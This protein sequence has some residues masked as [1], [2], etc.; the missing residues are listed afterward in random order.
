MPSPGALLR[1]APPASCTVYA[2][3]RDGAQDASRRSCDAS[4][5]RG[6]LR[7]TPSRRARTRT[8]LLHMH[9]HTHNHETERAFLPPPALHARFPI[10]LHKILPA[11]SRPV[12]ARAACWQVGVHWLVGLYEN[13]LNGI[14]GDEMGLGKTVQSIAL[15]AHLRGMN[16][17]GPFLVV[18]PLSTLHNW[19]NEFRRWAPGM[20]AVVYHGSKEE[21]ARLRGTHWRQRGGGHLPVMITSY[22]IVIRDVKEL[23]AMRW[24]FVIIDEGHRLK[25][26]NCRLIRELKN[27]CGTS[28]CNRLLLTGTPL[29]NNLTELW[30]LLNF[31][32]PAIFDDLDSF[33][34]WFDFDFSKENNEEKV[35]Q[36]E[37]QHSVVSKLH[38][39]LR[40]FLLRRLKADVE[41]LIPPKVEY[42]LFAALSEWQQAIYKEVLA[43][44][45][46]THDARGK[47]VRLNNVLMQLRKC[48]NHPYL[49][50]WPTDEATGAPAVNEVIVSASGKMMLLDRIM[51]RLFQEGGHKVRDRKR[52]HACARAS[53]MRVGR[54]VVVVGGGGEQW[55]FG[56][57][58]QMLGRHRVCDFWLGRAWRK[59]WPR[60]LP[61]E[62]V[63]G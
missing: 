54:R 63:H 36:G 34:A 33:Q 38:Q 16:V 19:A 26:M 44:S 48:C 42:I 46:T 28:E 2:A 40:P 52:A 39:I 47:E 49:F 37:L 5:G 9:T 15:L 18:G 25:N 13:G 45:F 58:K 24:K 27:L 14:L 10:C 53:G 23:R 60:V 11:V 59:G 6:W 20:E 3:A 57:G 35:L 7:K 51:T 22:E 4:P 62:S 17:A 61:E 50:E 21:R 12:R 32:L 43:K 29:Q 1:D 41:L 30:S 31:L 8:H 55:T 56:C